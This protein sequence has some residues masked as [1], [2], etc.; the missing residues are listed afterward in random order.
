[1][2][3]SWPLS[4]WVCNWKKKILILSN[5]H[6]YKMAAIENETEVII[7]LTSTSNQPIKESNPPHSFIHSCHNVKLYQVYQQ[8][9]MC[10]I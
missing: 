10:K 4:V 1:M 5:L 8:L 6:K 2:V 9:L 3:K 7:L